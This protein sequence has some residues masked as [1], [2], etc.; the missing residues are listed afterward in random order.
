M[1][2]RVIIVTGANTGIGYAAAQNLCEGGN[3]VILA[4]RNEEKGKAAVE[5]ILKKH[6]N[7]LATFM[8]LDL[9]DMASIRKFVED[10]HETGKK[11]NVLINN[12]GVYMLQKQWT[13]DNFE[14]TVG[15]NHLGPFLLTHLL[16]DD[17]K[18]TASDAG[19]ARI[20]N[21]TSSLH[22]KAL[23]IR[24]APEMLST[25]DFFLDKEGA[26]T[27][28]QSYRN[29]KLCN[30]LMTQSLSKQLD[31][32]GV[33]CNCVCPGMVKDTELMRQA[34]AVKRFFLKYFANTLMKLRI[35]S[36]P[37]HSL[38]EG[39]R[40]LVELSI[41]EE[42][43]GVT[44]KF[45]SNFEEKKSS[46]DSLDEELQKNVYELSARYCHLEGYE[47]LDAPA[48][49]PQEEK[50][51]SKRK[52]KKAKAVDETEIEDKGGEKKDGEEKKDALNTSDGIQFADADTSKLEEG[53]KDL[54]EKTVEKVETTEDEP[55]VDEKGDADKP[56]ELEPEDKEIK[57]TDDAVVIE[58]QAEVTAQ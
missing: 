38:E 15:T 26:Y 18:K 10:F 58:T 35:R 5:Q 1:T 20:I 27:P 6:P 47:P 36:I 37:A 39:G 25:E 7:A 9:A 45:F 12:A 13:K 16:L 46:D 44:G 54:E 11:L 34:G 49:P 40:C 23:K 22:D 55:K 43:K 50:P 56:K 29:S 19:E 3:D 8:Q 30:V 51:K 17:L 52:S 28:E 33:T 14:M 31:G 32:T 41:N 48:P 4:C 2:G 42:Q 53:K 57:K 21:V 24:K